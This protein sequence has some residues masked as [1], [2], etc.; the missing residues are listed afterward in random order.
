[1]KI[2]IDARTI[3]YP[4]TKDAIGLGHY[5]FQLIKHLLEIDQDNEYVLFF[6]QDTRE[7]DIVRFTKDNVKIVYYPFSAY[8]KFLPGMYNEI[9]TSATLKKEELDVLHMISPL[10]RV[11][12]SYRGT[13]VT[14]VHDLGMY[15]VPENYRKIRVAHT[16]AITALTLKRAQHI[17]AASQALKKDVTELFSIDAQNISTVYT[18]LDKRF[19]QSR[20][21]SQKKVAKKFGITKKYILFLGTVHPVKNITR[22]LHAFSLFSQKR[23]QLHASD[24]C[25]YQLL[26][27][28]KPG[29]LSQDIKNFVRDLDVDRDVKFTGYITGDEVLPLF[30]HADFFVSP[31]LYEG[32]GSTIVEAFAAGTPVIASNVGSIPEIA[33]DAAYLINPMD[34]HALTQALEDFAKEKELRESYARKG[35]IRARDFSWEKTAK[36]TLAVY[37]KVAQ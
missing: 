13:V 17:I 3:L 29:W 30:H 6:D 27:A 7:K 5:T 9:L 36:Q 23:R 14:T 8:T 28:G 31:S 25:D 32:F 2:G 24:T 35:M 15:K 12:V 1:M 21:D 34:T 20:K 33:A 16:K 11:P 19:F 22:L 37:K 26:I 18:G 10:A 4:K